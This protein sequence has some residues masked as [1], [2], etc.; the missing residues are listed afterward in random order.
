MTLPVT[1]LNGFLGAGKTTLLQNLL[2]QAHE[3]EDICIGVIVNELS[4]LDIDGETL[5]AVEM[6][7]FKSQRLASVPAGSISA[8]D[9]LARFR[10]AVDTI[11][12]NPRIT[13][14]LIE[15]SGSTHP[16]PL[17]S[18]MRQIPELTLHGFLSVV[19]ALVLSQDYDFG[20]TIMSAAATNLAAGKRGVE[21]L[22]A[23]QIMFAS[24][25]LLSKADRLTPDALQTIGSAIHPLNPYVDIIGVQ[26]G[27][28]PL[29]AVT[30]LPE[31]DYHRIEKLGNELTDWEAEHGA[32]PVSNP[33]SYRIGS[34]ELN[35][36]RPFHPSRLW[37]TY[38][39][40]LGIGIY[41][42]KGFFWLPSRSNLVL[43]WN[44]TA[45]NIGLQIINHWKVSLLEDETLQLLPEEISG[46]KE[47]LTGYPPEFGD[48]QCR[49]T[50]I[51]DEEQLDEFVSALRKCFC[52][53][54]EI[55]AWKRGE[56]FDDPWPKNVETLSFG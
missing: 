8:P 32:E 9:G 53:P 14:L 1:I 43:L 19:D 52:T 23:E 40:Y 11:I 49:L 26:W 34:R 29:D 12:A 28:I 39:R 2:V 42:S 51:G 22:M 47:K 3:R 15:T 56:P 48:R 13:H 37:E 16:W 27:N 5:D 7:A 54:T 44:Q 33:I 17:I 25:V 50:I 20:R 24:R 10:Q 18:M 46:M 4:P 21:N 45:G 36:P 35:D 30:G 41:R 6:L 31:Y 55:A 38:N